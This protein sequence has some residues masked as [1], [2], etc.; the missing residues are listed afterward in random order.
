MDVVSNDHLEKLVGA[1]GLVVIHFWASWCKPCATL[2]KVLEE[3]AKKHEGKKVTFVRVEAEACP[4]VS[5]KH[6]ISVVPT[7]LLLRGGSCERIEGAKTAE[8]VGAVNRALEGGDGGVTSAPAAASSSA[9]KQEEELRARLHKLV[10]HAPVMLFM[11][12]TPAAPQCGFSR[13]AVELLSKTG[14]RYSSFNILEHPDVRAGLKKVYNWPTFPQLY[15]EGSLVGGLDVLKELAEE[16]SLK[17]S[18]PAAAFEA[19]K[20]AEGAIDFAAL[21]SRSPV[22]LF[23]KGSP[24]HPK[25][26]FSSSMVTLLAESGVRNYDSFDILSDERV[27]AGLKEYSQWPT[28]PQLYVQGKLLGGLDVVRDMVEDDALIDLIPEGFKK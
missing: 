1:G 26:G 12:G 18:L 21:T 8:L 6:K 9:E 17:T 4:E 19:E 11:K 16:D 23:M 7:F 5:E 22:M 10:N 27:R 13:Q 15:C 25:C 28:F 3:L 14:A 2:D 24:Q 20:A